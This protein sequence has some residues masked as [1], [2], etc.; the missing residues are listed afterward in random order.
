MKPGHFSGNSG[1]II[2]ALSDLC[3]IRRIILA[4]APFTF[5]PLNG[6]A[7]RKSHTKRLPARYRKLPH[8]RRAMLCAMAWRDSSFDRETWMRSR[9]G[10]SICIGILRLLNAWA[11]RHAVA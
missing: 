7:A 8:A 5:F 2:F 1:A 9:Q 6:K 10:L 3:A 11:R 4:R